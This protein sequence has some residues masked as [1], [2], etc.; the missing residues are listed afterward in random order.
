MEINTAILSILRDC[1][2][3]T[4]KITRTNLRWRVSSL[5]GRNVPDRALRRAIEE[6]RVS[7][8]EGACI[9]SSSQSGGG[10]WM[11]ADLTELSA[12]LAEERRRG[13]TILSGIH[14][15]A[16]RAGVQLSGQMEFPIS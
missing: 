8:R 15:Q 12:H 3:R 16:S 9:C 1:K 2:G 7:T 6:L 5:V 4:R 14:A 11:A 13:L 10:Y